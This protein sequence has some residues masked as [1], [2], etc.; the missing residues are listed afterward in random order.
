MLVVNKV[1]S[2]IENVPLTRLCD[3]GDQVSNM[4]ELTGLPLSSS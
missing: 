3:Y 4:L 1:S 2:E